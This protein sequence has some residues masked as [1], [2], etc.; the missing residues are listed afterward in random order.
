MYVTGSSFG[1]ATHRDIATVAY[2]ATTGAPLWARRF[3]GNHK[4]DLPASLAVSPNGA[5]VIIA[6]TSA[7]AGTATQ[8]NRFLVLAYS[9][10]GGTKLW[11]TRLLQDVGANDTASGVVVS[12]DSRTCSRPGAR[13]P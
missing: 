11:S 6:G 3:D 13:T 5:S 1:G 9:A 7:A 12:P 4:A 8:T 2:S 10:V